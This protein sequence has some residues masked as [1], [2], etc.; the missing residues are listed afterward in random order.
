M[1]HRSQVTRSQITQ[2]NLQISPYRLY[3]FLFLLLQLR[4]CLIVTSLTEIIAFGAAYRSRYC[5]I[6]DRDVF[7]L[8][9]PFSQ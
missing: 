6:A 4:I 7:H 8:L 9:K 5:Y 3:I 1:F 2:P